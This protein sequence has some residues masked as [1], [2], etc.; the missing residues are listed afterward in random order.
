MDRRLPAQSEPTHP[1]SH[2]HTPRRA[3]Q[4]FGPTPFAVFEGTPA[5]LVEPSSLDNSNNAH[6]PRDVLPPPF[7]PR[8]LSR[9]DPLA[10][11]S[12]RRHTS[13]RSRCCCSASR[14]RARGSRTLGSGACRG[15]CARSISRR[16]ALCGVVVFVL[17]RRVQRGMCM[18]RWQRAASLKIVIVPPRSTRSNPSTIDRSIDRSIDPI[19][20][21]R[22]H[23]T[24]S[25]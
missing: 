8:S 5:S 15:C 9:L 16:A 3:T 22:F 19:R 24:Q 18:P 21:D 1:T 13:P 2:T 20:P 7:L 17:P 25:I 23:W 11:V 14:P 10:L 4:Q 12:P 6:S